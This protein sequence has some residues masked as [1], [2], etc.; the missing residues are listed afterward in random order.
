V[1]GCSGILS[2]CAG[3][4]C[5]RFLLQFITGIPVFF[6]KNIQSK[7]SF[8]LS[9]LL[10]D[11]P[12]SRS[13]LQMQTFVEKITRSNIFSMHQ[14]NPGIPECLIQVTTK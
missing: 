10:P 5:E 12:D 8:S 9:S 7:G 2:N 1:K 4:N 11:W 3:K 14:K 6:E 13:Y